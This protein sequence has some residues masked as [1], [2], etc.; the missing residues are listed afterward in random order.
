MPAN[1]SMSAR[2]SRSFMLC[3]RTA[4]SSACRFRQP[5]FR[6]P[7]CLLTFSA[8][9]PFF[10]AGRSCWI[11]RRRASIKFTTVAGGAVGAS[12]VGGRPACFCF[13]ISTTA[14]S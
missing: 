14:V 3:D 8:A 9:L 2:R 10:S 1:R 6:L 4:H 11:E 7:D 12:F 5:A 13:S